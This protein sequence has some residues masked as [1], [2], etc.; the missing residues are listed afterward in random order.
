MEDQKIYVGVCN[1]AYQTETKKIVYAGL[2]REACRKAIYEQ[3]YTDNSTS[4][5]M[6][7]WVDGI[8]EYECEC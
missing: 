2:D 3:G 6:E 1:Y 8:K 5:F 4:Q 7:I